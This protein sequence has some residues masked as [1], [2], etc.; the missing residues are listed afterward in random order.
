M[1]GGYQYDPHAFDLM[2]QLFSRQDSHMG[3]ISNYV[4]ANCQASGAFRGIIG[5]LAGHYEG[6]YSDAQQG[7]RDGATI[8]QHCASKISESKQQVL[9]DD[10]AAYDRMAALA[11]RRGHPMPPWHAPAGGTGPLGEGR[12]MSGEDESAFLKSLEW[13][14]SRYEAGSKA[15][16]RALT[17]PLEPF[18][19]GELTPDQYLDPRSLIQHQISKWSVSAQDAYYERLAAE[20]PGGHDAAYFREQHLLSQQD[21]FEHGFASGQSFAQDHLNTHAGSTDLYHS[22]WLSEDGRETLHTGVEEGGKVLNIVS[23]TP[24]LIEAGQH[25]HEAQDTSAE[26]DQTAAGPSNV[27]SYRWATKD[28]SGG[29]W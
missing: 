28:N 14:R 22:P 20:D 1:G 15:A 2:N 4:A 27:G 18:K 9:S 10:K 17:D 5:P 19:P 3:A 13:V 6:A 16:N 24:A 26:L 21:R 23:A 11:K 12:P 8:A 25:L 7:M 29:E